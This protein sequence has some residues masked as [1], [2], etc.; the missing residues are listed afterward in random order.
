MPPEIVALI[1]K[2]WLLALVLAIGAICGM[3]VERIGEKW[4]RSERRAYWEKRNCGKNRAAGNGGFGQLKTVPAKGT[5]E[6]QVLGAADQLRLVMEASFKPRPLL[7]KSE[8]RLFRELDK[9]VI[10]RNPDWQVMA[11]SS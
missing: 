9:M 2:P 5:L 1:D 11:K 7:N 4:N 10:A 8:A 3:A 6:R